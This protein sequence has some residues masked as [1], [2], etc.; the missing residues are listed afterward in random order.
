M[1][2]LHFEYVFTGKPSELGR[3]KLLLFNEQKIISVNEARTGSVTSQGKLV[4]SIKP[5]NDNRIWT[6]KIIPEMCYDKAEYYRMWRR[7]EPGFGWKI[8][9]F[10]N[11]QYTHYLIHPDGGL[12]G[13][14]GCIGLLSNGIKFYE[15]MINYGYEAERE[16]IPLEIER[17]AA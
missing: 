5:S 4:N 10:E 15:S 6:A 13:T 1:I 16:Y 7:K 17:I 9:L 2:R 8:R 12:G 3:G 11:G 14:K